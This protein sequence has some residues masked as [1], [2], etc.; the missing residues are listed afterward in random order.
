MKTMVVNGFDVQGREE[1]KYGDVTPL[2]SG[3]F[4][5]C[6]NPVKPASTLPL[7][8][9][10]QDADQLVFWDGH[11]LPE[12]SVMARELS[13]GVNLAPL[14]EARVTPEFGSL[15]T[16]DTGP[17]AILNTEHLQN[18]LHIRLDQDSALD[19]PLELVFVTDNQAAGKLVTPRVMITA[20]AGSKATII[21]R[22]IGLGDQ[23]VL[24]VPVMEIFCEAG[25]RLTHL[26]WVGNH[27]AAMH[28]G[29]TH[30][31][32][33]AESSYT[34]REFLLGG[35]RIRREL[36]VHLAGAQATCTLTGLSLTDGLRHSDVRTRVYHDVPDCTTHENYKGILADRGQ[37]VFDGLIKVAHGASQTQA[38]QTNR[39]LLL[40][41]DAISYSIPRLEIYT[42]DVKCSHG[43]TTGQ[44]GQD[45]LFYLRSRGFDAAMAR[46]ML[47][48]AFA[49][50]IVDEV[51]HEGLRDEITT[52][53]H[54]LLDKV[55]G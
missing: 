42:D 1:W 41:D 7:L 14:A 53:I 54:K 21:E 47:S 43:S 49:S 28:Y 20:A 11:F 22:H 8:P 2:A 9:G 25:A 3:D 50:E 40:S 29:S 52:E 39:N 15:A 13:F 38:D 51:E 37:S 55:Q 30:V 31:L 6:Q 5:I 17:L 32:Q 48:Y 10:C 26:K 16:P 44:L 45:E 23:P 12:A 34:S 27:S 4:T 46:R 18:V 19:R 24:C 33:Q 35:K 36:H